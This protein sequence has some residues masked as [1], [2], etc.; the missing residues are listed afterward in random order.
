MSDWKQGR[1]ALPAVILGFSLLG[2]TVLAQTPAAQGSGNQP[3]PTATGPSS[4]PDSS[5]V[6]GAQQQLYGAAGQ[7]G[8]QVTQDSFKGS[9]VEG[10]STGAVMDLPLDDAI[11]RGL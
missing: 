10:K 5:A 6:A 4:G 11:Q 1:N 7:N 9:I 2:T 8:A 3:R